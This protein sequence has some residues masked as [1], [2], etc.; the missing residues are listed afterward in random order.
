[1]KNFEEHYLTY[2]RAI[3]DPSID[4]N[5]IYQ[6]LLDSSIVVYDSIEN[7]EVWL[8][9][10]LLSLITETEILIP[11]SDS[12]KAIYCS[13]SL[14]RFELIYNFLS[15]RD[16]RYYIISELGQVYDFYMALNK[17]HVVMRTIIYLIWYSVKNEKTYPL[18]IN[19]LNGY[20]LNEDFE[21]RTILFELS[22]Y[23]DVYCSTEE[24]V[25]LNGKYPEFANY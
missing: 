23:M 24:R 3:Y 17:P 6:K 7:I 14:V 12:F 13:D 5:N 15:Q 10:E 9:Q 25:A 20:F 21:D 18:I 11:F 22:A 16:T 4:T 19:L 2:L 8:K 1:M